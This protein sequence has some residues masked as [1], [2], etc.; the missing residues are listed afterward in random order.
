[1]YKLL[2]GFLPNI[3]SEICLVNNELHNHFT[4]QS[5]FLHPRK[6]NNHV[7]TQSFNHIGPRIWNSLQKKVNVLVPLVKFKIT[8]KVFSMF[9]FSNLITRNSILDPYLYI[10]L[11]LCYDIVI[12]IFSTLIV[13][14]IAYIYN[15]FIQFILLFKPRMLDKKISCTASTNPTSRY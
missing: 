1:M 4:R 11:T 6:G 3:M 15:T 5:H 8:S 14:C 7:Y 10:L 2:N 9:I 12:Y 13:Y